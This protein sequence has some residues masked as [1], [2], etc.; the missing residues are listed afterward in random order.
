[1]ARNSSLRSDATTPAT[2]ACFSLST[3]MTS[4][5]SGSKWRERTCFLFRIFAVH[6]VTLIVVFTTLSFVFI[7]LCVFTPRIT[8]LFVRPIWRRH[9]QGGEVQQC[10][11]ASCCPTSDPGHDKKAS[12]SPETKK[13][14]GFPT[15]T[16]KYF[17]LW[18]PSSSWSIW[19]KTR[20][21]GTRCSSCTLQCIIYFTD[22]WQSFLFNT[23]LVGNYKFFVLLAQAKKLK[24]DFLFL[25]HSCLNF[26]FFFFEILS[27]LNQAVPNHLADESQT[28]LPDTPP[29]CGVSGER[30]WL[31]SDFSGW[32]L[33]IAFLYLFVC[34]SLLRLT[35]F[36]SQYKNV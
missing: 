10:L 15:V 8:D 9:T 2:T 26:F 4:R 28:R 34:H 21:G 22:S 18:W 5:I 13:Q 19:P 1:M 7:L 16:E 30:V 12:Y 11:R 6:S 23:D 14:S 24:I 31:S 17:S 36:L 25:L 33:A 29:W 20:Y 27:D 32:R 3:I 35:S